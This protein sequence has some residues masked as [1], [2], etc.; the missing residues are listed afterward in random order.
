MGIR[1][2]LPLNDFVT[3]RGG[4]GGRRRYWC[5]HHYY[6]ARPQSLTEAFVRYCLIYPMIG[7][8]ALAVGFIVAPIAGGAWL[9]RRQLRNK[10]RQVRAQR[11]PVQRPA[12]RPAPRPY[13]FVPAQRPVQPAPYGF[14]PAQRPVPAPAY[15]P[16]RRAVTR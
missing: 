16:A 8:L 4:I 6:P 7:M 14:V 3:L 13:G 9:I 2:S 12:P 15:A 5:G 11:F 10:E 1:Y